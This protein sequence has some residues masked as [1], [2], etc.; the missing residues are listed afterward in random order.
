MKIELKNIKYAEFA[1]QETNCY[2]ASLHVNGRK[3]GLVYNEGHGG[4][5]GFYPTQP[6]DRKIYSEADAWC[7][8]NL[9]ATTYGDMTIEADLECHCSDLLNDHL[10]RKDM[11]RVTG[12]KAAFSCPG[13]TGLFT[14]KNPNGCKPDSALFAEVLRRHPGAVILNT[15]PEAEALAL[16][17]GAA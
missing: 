4:P 14:L 11:K 16:W 9:P 17:K 8:A 5:D 10:I 6:S 2:E 3:I 7:K 15:L 12:R 1:S 13:E